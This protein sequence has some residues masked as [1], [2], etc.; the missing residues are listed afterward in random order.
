MGVILWDWPPWPGPWPY[1]GSGE[2][3]DFS[4]SVKLEAKRRAHFACVWCQ[5]TEFFI[6]VHHIIPQEVGGPATID[7]AA[8]LCPGCHTNLGGNADL[9][10]QLRERRDWWW[11]FCKNRAAPTNAISL[12]HTNQL[13]ER[14]KTVEAQGQRS[15]QLL[16]ELKDIV[17]SAEDKRRVAVS[18]ART[19]GELS[20][21]TTSPSTVFGGDVFGKIGR[22]IKPIGPSTK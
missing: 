19:V 22:A 7:N 11:D 13:F 9:R 17:L 20:D 10:K 3:V 12:E 21:L 4:D 2:R 5:R 14:L 6:Q 16:G 8:P 18:S 1:R 15:E